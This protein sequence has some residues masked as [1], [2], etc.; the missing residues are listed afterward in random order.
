[1][2]NNNKKPSSLSKLMQYSG[3]YKAMIYTSWLFAG[4]SAVFTLLPFWFIWKIISEAVALAPDFSNP[5]H[6]K[7]NA[8]YAM[9]CALCAILFYIGGLLCSHLGAFRVATNLRLH[10]IR[11]ISF[12]PPGEK[13]RIGSG[14]LRR[15]ISDSTEASETYLAHQLPDQSKSAVMFI[16]L[17]YLMFR[18]DWRLA[19]LCLIPVVIGFLSL[20]S[21]AGKGLREKMT[22][23]QNA[24]SDMSNEAV[25]YIR[26]IPVVKTFN[27]TVFSF[28]RF[29]DSIDRYSTWASG[30]SRDVRLPILI[31]TVAINSIFLFLYLSVNLIAKGN[32]DTEFILKIIF[33]VIISP[34]MTAMLT[35]MMSSNETKLKVEDAI[36]RMENVLAI[37]PLVSSNSA[38]PAGYSVAF[39]NVSFSYD[40]ETTVLNHISFEVEQGKTFALVGPSGGGKSTIASLATRFFDPDEGRITIGGVSLKDI[41]KK[42]LMD[43]VSF[44]FQDA[45]LIQGSILD[46]LRL[47]KPEASEKEVYQALETAQC[48]DIIEKFP[49]G[50]HTVIG[51]EGVYLS[52][53]E[54]QRL[55]IARA[56]LKNAP[57][58]ILDEAT[59]F[60]DPD[61]EAKIQ[62]AIGALSR[63]KTI[64]MIAHRLSTVRHADRICVVENGSIAEQGSFDEL[65]AKK[66]TF[67]SMW[68]EYNRSVDWK[69]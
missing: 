17:M 9:I 67:A 11:H 31:Y 59:A 40:K 12:L 35:S 7:V 69:L 38:H 56:I 42:E 61:N 36:S 64:I 39:E 63:N 14:A 30:Y 13:D 51:S 45:K 5:H 8:I 48:M 33:F 62:A 28:K 49:T 47:G 50:I 1:M 20:M 19:L 26:G 66:G 34:I 23:Y 37:K 44:V 52:G 58:L 57:V 68:E 41:P 10:L 29:K 55:T 4:L 18:C 3:N 43:N 16:G 46:N 54:Q 24:L 60:A 6:M 15:V 22:N 65:L 27:Q 25:E 2:K 53:G 21:M 32:V